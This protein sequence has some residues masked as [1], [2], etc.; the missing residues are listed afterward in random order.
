[1]TPPCG[2]VGPYAHDRDPGQWPT[3]PLVDGRA[4]HLLERWAY[5]LA[6]I[7]HAIG[8]AEMGAAY[9]VGQADLRTF[10]YGGDP[11]LSC[12]ADSVWPTHINDPERRALKKLHTAALGRLT[13]DLDWLERELQAWTRELERDPAR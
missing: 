1:M 8:Q 9:G 3:Q 13:Y 4:Y 10:G 5:H 2:Y 12:L 7:C 6:V 11:V